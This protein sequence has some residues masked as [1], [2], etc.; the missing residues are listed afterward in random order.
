MLGSTTMLSSPSISF[1]WGRSRKASTTFSLIPGIISSCKHTTLGASPRV[2]TVR[3]GILWPANLSTFSVY[4][5][6]PGPVTSSRNMSSPSKAS[7]EIGT[8]VINRLPI[9]VPSCN[10]N[11]ALP[12]GWTDVPFTAWSIFGAGFNRGRRSLGIRWYSRS[13]I[14]VLVQPVS[15][16]IGQPTS[17]T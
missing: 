5:M 9:Q 6:S 16:Q 2:P 12:S 11:I 13:D 17:L 14:V 15:T 8:T 10:L 4:K 7:S 3:S 1:P